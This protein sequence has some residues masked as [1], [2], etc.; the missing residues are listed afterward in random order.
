M[1]RSTNQGIGRPSPPTSDFGI[2]QAVIDGL[3]ETA[4]QMELKWGVRRLR[5]LVDDDLRMRFDAQKAKLDAALAS[6][7]PGYIRSQGEG[8]RRAWSA[9]DKAATEAGAEPLS[10]E[11]WECQLPSSGE[12]VSVVRT[13]A[14]AQHVARDGEVWTM[15]EVAVL[16]ER[17]GHEARQ[18]KR[19][20]PGSAVVDIGGRDPPDID[21]PF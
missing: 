7:Q 18:V 11:V 21:P 1:R 20:F 15:A 6:N 2:A 5:L 14:E 8:M 9:L 13:E 16:I 4:Q 3:D 17:L 12:V 19:T 10:P